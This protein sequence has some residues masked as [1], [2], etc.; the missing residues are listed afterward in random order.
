[1]TTFF[2]CFTIVAVTIIVCGTI[3]ATQ[4]MDLIRKG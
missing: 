3:L 2:I 4:I 1:M